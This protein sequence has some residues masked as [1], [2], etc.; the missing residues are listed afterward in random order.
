M[1]E[2]VLT[3]SPNK[4]YRGIF[5][6]TMPATTGPVWMPLLISS[7]RADL[8]FNQ[9]VTTQLKWYL[10]Y[11]KIWVYYQTKKFTIYSTDQ[12]MLSTSCFKDLPKMNG[13]AVKRS[14]KV[15]RESSYNLNSW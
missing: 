9:K 6:P 1:R 2:A 5:V 12:E 13:N 10:Q 15:N 4:Q 3:V 7:V 8:M 14:Q 11:M